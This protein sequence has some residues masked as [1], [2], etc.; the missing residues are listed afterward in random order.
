MGRTGPRRRGDTRPERAQTSAMV[1]TVGKLCIVWDCWERETVRTEQTSGQGQT[2]W[3]EMDWAAAEA[4]VKRLQGRIYRAAGGCQ[5][6][7]A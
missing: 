2:A 5:A 4:V 1:S 3:S 6:A 7:E